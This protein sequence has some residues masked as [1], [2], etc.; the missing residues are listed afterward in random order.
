MEQIMEILRGMQA[1]LEATPP[2]K[3]AE[4]M[5]KWDANAHKAMAKYDFHLGEA[6]EACDEKMEACQEKKKESTPKETEVVA[7]PEEVPKGGMDEETS[8]GTEGRTGEQRLATRRH[9]QRKKRAQENGGPRQKFAAFHG[10]PTR[11]FVPALRKGGLRKGPGKKCCSGIR[12]RGI[13]SRSG[14]RGR[15]ID[16]VVGGAPEGRTDGREEEVDA[17][18]MQQWHPETEQG[19]PHW[20]ERKDCE[21]G[22]T[23]RQEEDVH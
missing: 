2:E 6:T 11:H 17:P 20:E 1:E 7:E 10:Q 21:E 8:G 23:C 5:A 12:G 13:T 3:T 16:N 22:S 19:I 9:R 18:G 4:L 15:T 14:K